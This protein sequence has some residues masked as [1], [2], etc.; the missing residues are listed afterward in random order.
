MIECAKIT[1]LGTRELNE[2]AIRVMED[3][4]RYG[5]IVCD[6]LGGH[7]MGDVANAF[8]ECFKTLDCVGNEF[9]KQMFEC[10]QNS[11]LKQK[12]TLNVTRQM[13]TTAVALLIENN[14][15]YIGYI[16]DSRLYVVENDSVSYRTIDHSVPQMLALHGDIVDE[17]IPHHPDRNKLL[18]ALGKEW[19]RPMYCIEKPLELK[20]NQGFLLCSD[21][22]WEWIEQ[23]QIISM[24]KASNSAK[25]WLDS[26][27]KVVESNSL[28]A[29]MDNCSA[30][31]VINKDG[32]GEEDYDEENN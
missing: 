15:A 13:C 11:L 6:G 2:D 10:A 27:M 3:N 1:K 14:K 29:E 30:I 20:N 8:V 23:K 19:E 17:D 22:F 4:G 28:D 25:Q 9:M 16:G 26:M 24:L 21:G 31:V 32:N 7:G 12:K 5:F 18:R